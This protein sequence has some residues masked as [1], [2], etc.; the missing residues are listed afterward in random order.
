MPYASQA[1]FAAEMPSKRQ[2]QLKAA[3]K[4]K[5]EKQGSESGSAAAAPAALPAA[6]QR[7]P[8]KQ[9]AKPRVRLADDRSASTTQRRRLLESGKSPDDMPPA[10]RAF[11]E[12]DIASRQASPFSFVAALLIS[13]VCCSQMTTKSLRLSTQFI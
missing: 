1:C 5:K 7:P 9:D 10:L 12:Q 4:K 11:L 13:F 3:R 6:A 2:L 8:K